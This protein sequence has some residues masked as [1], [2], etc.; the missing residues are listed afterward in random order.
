MINATKT[1]ERVKRKLG[2]PVR[3][4]ELTDEQMTSLLKDAQETFYLYANMAGMS[5]TE[6]DIIEDAWIKKFFYA[7][8]K[9]TLG[10][11]RGKFDGAINVPGINDLKLDYQ[12]LLEEAGKEKYF[13]KYAIFKEKELLKC[14]HIE[15][16][17]LV[18]YLNIGSMDNSDVDKY[19]KEIQQKMETPKGFTT[20]FLPVRTTES[21]IECIYPVGSGLGDDGNNVIDRL[22]NYLNELTDEED[23]KV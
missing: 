13:L 21:R 16:A 22:N 9:E 5:E 4:V 18:V 14:N 8:C 19:I 20:Y 12:S 3:N 11:I 2:A 10:R 6:Q 15:S 17:I 1:I 23:G 7:L